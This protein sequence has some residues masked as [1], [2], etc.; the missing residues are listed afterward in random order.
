MGGRFKVK[1]LQIVSV[2]PPAYA[3]GGPV[4]VAYEISK[5]LVKKGHGVTVYTTDAYDAHS[6]FKYDNN[7]MWMNGIEVYHFKNVSNKLAHRENLATAPRMALALNRNIKDFDI[8]HLHEY[9]SFQAI[10]VHYY[11]KKHEIHYV[12]QAHGA[13][14]G[15]IEK[16]RL[17]KLY[18]RVWG[19]MIL[20]DASEVIALTKTE[21]KQYKKMDVDEDKI[22]IV[23]N[24]INL[25]EYENLPEKGEFRRKYSISDDEKIILYLGRIHKI[26]GIDLLVKAFADLIEGLDDVRLVLVGHD[27]GF[28]STLKRQIEDLK[29]GDRILFTGSLY[30]RDKLEAYVD[31]DVYVLPS[32]YEIFGITL[33]EACACGT[34]VIVTDRCGIADFVDGKVGYVVEYDKNQLRDAIFK[35]LSD[36]GLRR[37]FGEEG[38]RLVEE[39]FNWNRIAEKVE[40]VYKCTLNRE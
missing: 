32:V 14:P 12:L 4:K 6:R 33:L 20:R 21:A 35:I 5:E 28:L 11:A 13:L 37:R 38:K 30:G 8:V 36:E 25:S 17:K 22:E 39:R 16:Q 24:G 40:N 2:F 23:P 3:Y 10:L 26:K 15:I 1:V 34:S 31:A 29:I 7:P 19:Y 9:R 27:D 18:D